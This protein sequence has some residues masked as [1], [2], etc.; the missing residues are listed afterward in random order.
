MIDHDDDGREQHRHPP[1]HHK[2]DAFPEAVD[3][4]AKEVT[5]KIEV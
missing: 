2:D 4:R 1:G 3:L 5:M